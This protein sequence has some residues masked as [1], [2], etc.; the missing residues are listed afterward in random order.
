MLLMDSVRDWMRNCNS[1]VNKLSL[2]SCIIQESVLSSMKAE[3]DFKNRN[4]VK[5]MSNPSSL[6]DIQQLVEEHEFEIGEGGNCQSGEEEGPF[7][8]S[9][10]KQSEYSFNSQAPT[11]IFKYEPKPSKVKQQ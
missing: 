9:F 4:S 3:A 2:E 8:S 1:P 6:N 10:E 11:T 7:L 5:F